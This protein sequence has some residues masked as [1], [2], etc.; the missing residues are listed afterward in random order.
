MHYVRKLKTISEDDLQKVSSLL[1]VALQTTVTTLVAVEDRLKSM[2]HTNQGF[3]TSEFNEDLDDKDD[4][5]DDGGVD[6][7]PTTLLSSL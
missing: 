4:G 2:L 7:L 3:H 6:D 1:Y 5:D